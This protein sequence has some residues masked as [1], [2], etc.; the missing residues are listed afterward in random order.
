MH[1]LAEY[2][3]LRERYAR[4]RQEA[5]MARLAKMVRANREVKPG[6]ARN[7]RRTFA[8]YTGLSSAPSQHHVRMPLKAPEAASMPRAVR[9]AA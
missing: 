1:G 4:V 6:L 3:F 2:E 5:E 7:L 8:R 9:R